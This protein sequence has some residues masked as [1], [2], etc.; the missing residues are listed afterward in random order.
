MFQH[1]RKSGTVSTALSILELIY[2]ATVRDVRK[3]HNNAFMA[4]FKN[5][6]QVLLFVI[7]FYVMFSVLGLRGSAVRGDFLLYVMSGIFLFM[8]HIKAVGAV[9]GSG[10]ANSPMMLH[11]PMNTMIS[12]MSAAFSSLYIQVLSMFM[13]L[14]VYHTLFAPITIIDP[15]GA[16]AMVLL[17]WFTGCAVGLIFMSL[18]PWFPTFVSVAVTIYQRANMIAS[19]KMFLANSLPGFM[20]PYFVWNP[21]FHT[22]DQARGYVFINYNPHFSSWEYAFWVGVVLW[23]LGLMGEFY[24]RRHE[25][26]SWSA[27]R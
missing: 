1:R 9:S 20:L 23:M 10:G 6:L 5:M 16:F 24:T 25:S 8:C 13:I 21:L 11:A 2:H 7:V 3:A 14:F 26:I 27:R 12:I 4:I 22:I 18:R 17:S 15:I 19:G